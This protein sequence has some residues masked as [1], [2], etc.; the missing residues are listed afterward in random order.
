[1]VGTPC[2]L[3]CSCRKTNSLDVGRSFQSRMQRS[4]RRRRPIR[5]K[6][7]AAFQ[8]VVWPG[9]TDV[10]DSVGKSSPLPAA[11]KQ[12]IQF[13]LVRQTW[14]ILRVRFYKLNFVP[15]TNASSRVVTPAVENPGST[16]PSCALPRSGRVHPWASDLARLRPQPFPT[17]C[18]AFCQE[19]QCAKLFLIE[20]MWP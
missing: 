1:M 8:A 3:K 18:N 11:R 6:Y 9:R 7:S 4:A 13:F 10:N 5:G 12:P 20:K 14:R 15:W 2:A 19:S 16:R 17:H